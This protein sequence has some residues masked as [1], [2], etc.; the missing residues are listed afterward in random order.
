[1]GMRHSIWHWHRTSLISP[2]A[3]LAVMPVLKSYITQPKHGN[4]LKRQRQ[5]REGTSRMRWMRF[6]V[7]KSGR[8][9]QADRVGVTRME[10]RWA[11]RI[12]VVAGQYS[13]GWA[14]RRVVKGREVLLQKRAR[15]GWCRPVLG[16]EP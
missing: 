14:V 4:D 3:P 10:H 12:E 15:G 1:M 11:G 16:H 2:R 5:G 13:D 7:M 6:I 8:S 9:D